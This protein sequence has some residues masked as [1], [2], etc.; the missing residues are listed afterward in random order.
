MS[1]LKYALVTALGTMFRFFPWPCKTGLME[2]GLPDRNSPVLLTCNYRLTVARVRRALRG[3]DA[4]LLVAN[5]RGINVWCAGTGGLLTNHDVV[6]ALKTSGIE[7]RVDHREVILPQ[8]AA[9][10]VEAREVEKKTGW[11]MIWGPVYAEEAPRFLKNGLEKNPAMREAR[12]PWRERIEMAVGWALLL[13]IIL[14]LVLIPLWREATVPSILLLWALS[15]LI[16]LT[17]PLYERWLTST[18]SNLVLV[19]FAVLW[20]ILVLAGLVYA[21][22][23]GDWSW[24]FV[25]RWG[26]VSGIIV[27]SLGLDFLGSTPVFKSGLH[28]D[29]L[30]KV[31]LDEETCR[32][33]GYCGQVCPRN[34]YEV[35]RERH[36]ASM[37]R[38]ERCV[39][40]GACIVQCP[41]DALHFRSP[42]GEVLSPET[43]RRFKLNLMGKRL[44]E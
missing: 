8:L 1:L 22:V 29:R 7:E 37:P 14:A 26:L 39:Q 28:E 36:K 30:L 9:T 3:V 11:K 15:L 32:G 6:S 17:F 38:Q 35:D 42:S 21:S 4:Y 12:F 27:F 24:G 33:A 5:S 18:G 19:G 34:C 40:C 44:V 25:L 20:V 31:I 2:I 43:I 41:F 13:S 10:G 16:Y 23:F